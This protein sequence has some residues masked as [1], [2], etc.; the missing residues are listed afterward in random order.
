MRSCEWPLSSLS[1]LINSSRD[2]FVSVP[3]QQQSESRGCI[4]Q[5]S[6]S[7]SIEWNDYIVMVVPKFMVVSTK[8]RDLCFAQ[9]SVARSSH[10]V[11]LCTLSHYLSQEELRGHYLQTY[12]GKRPH[13]CMIRHSNASY[14]NG[15][16]LK[17][18]NVFNKNRSR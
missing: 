13:V 6:N 9:A 17:T 5:M 18:C 11:F 10:L 16:K 2:L 8:G 3:R 4:S 15:P 7:V 14:P 12:V 1:I